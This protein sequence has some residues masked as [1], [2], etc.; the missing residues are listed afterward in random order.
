VI[1][2][3]TSMKL[4]GSDWDNVTGGWRKVDFENIHGFC[5]SPNI[6]WAIQPW[7]LI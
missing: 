7:G 6:I 2:N 5:I 1:Y 4:F 3:K